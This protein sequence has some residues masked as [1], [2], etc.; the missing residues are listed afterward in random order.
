M[1]IGYNLNIPA[2][3]H[4][5]ATDQPNMET[6]NNNIA[7]YVAVDHVP[8]NTGGS[9]QHEQVTFNANNIPSVPTSPPVLFTNVQDGAGNNLP[10]SIP[11][12]FYYSG[13]A[14]QG[15]N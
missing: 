5:P 12:L 2:A 9:G 10:N 1:G 6:N 13:S 4:A 11:E 15:K 7:T 3:N 8:F 14:A